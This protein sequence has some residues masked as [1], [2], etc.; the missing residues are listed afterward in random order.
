VFAKQQRRHIS[1]DGCTDVGKST[2]DKCI[3]TTW[4]QRVA[5]ND[6]T[7]SNVRI[8]RIFVTSRHGQLV[9]YRTENNSNN[10]TLVSSSV[11]TDYVHNPGICQTSAFFTYVSS[12]LSVWFVVC[13]TFDNYIR[14]CL[15][16]CV[17]VFCTTTIARRCIAALWL[18]ITAALSYCI[19]I[20]TTGVEDGNRYCTAK[21]DYIDIMLEMTYIDTVVT[22]FVPLLLITILMAAITADV[23]K[24]ANTR[25]RLTSARPSRPRAVNLPNR[26]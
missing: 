15:P 11:W 20:L 19:S 13:V 22:V 10:W 5:A 23:I 17:R 14:M 26:R 16:M 4:L 25:R 6:V 12:S 2:Y 24:S 21:S 3:Q 8:Q 7:G 18:M 1:I 9:N